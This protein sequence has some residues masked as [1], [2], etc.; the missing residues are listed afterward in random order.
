MPGSQPQNHYKVLGVEQNAT[1]E[2][3]KK[4]YRK[5]SKEFHPDRH[6]REG[7]AGGNKYK[8]YKEKFQEVCEA[9]EVL[10][11][12]DKRAV[13][14]RELANES[15][16][17]TTNTARPAQQADAAPRQPQYAE[18]PQPK[19]TAAPPRSAGSERQARSE[20]QVSHQKQYT[21][22]A[23]EVQSPFYFRPMQRP[24]AAAKSDNSEGVS[25]FSKNRSEPVIRIVVSPFI[26]CVMMSNMQLQAMMLAQIM[27]QLRL[28]QMLQ[29]QAAAQ[30][31]QAQHGRPYLPTC[32][33]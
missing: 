10:Q 6:G 21:Q 7:L 22:P 25:F 1:L 18:A 3:I 13:Y 14:D 15:S 9:Y 4:A 29:R 5:K 12:T 33:I 23:S 28:L 17:R 2:D 19:P 20:P 30:V 31:Q 16:A 32:R 8:E 26:F 27:L 24:V 11:D